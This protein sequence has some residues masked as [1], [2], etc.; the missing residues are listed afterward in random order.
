M[1]PDKAT[2]QYIEVVEDASTKQAPRAEV[3]V[4]GTVKLTEDTIVYIPAPTTDPRDP[5]NMSRWQKIIILIVLSTFSTLGVSMVSGF[6]GLITFYI[7]E[8]AAAGKDYAAISALMTYP[9]LFMGIGNLVGMPLA[10][11]VGRRIVLLVCT[12]ILV[13]GAVLC[14][15]ATSY[16]WHLGARMVIGISAGQSEALV[17]MITQEVFFLHE[18]SKFLM[19]QQTVQVILSTIYCL[20]ASPIAGALTPQGWYGLGAGLAGAQCF[21]AFFFLP[22]TK[23][24]RDL[25]AYQEPTST[26]EDDLEASKSGKARVMICKEKPPLDYL[27]FEKRTWKSDMRLW[28]G[29]PEWYKAVEVLK[30]TCELLF[31][32]NVLWALCLNGL[33]IGTNIAM[34]TT[35][36]TILTAA[37][38]NWPDTSTSYVSCGQIIVAIIALPLL[39]TGSDKLVRMRAE[40]NGGIHEPETRILPLILPIIVGTITA[41]FYGQGAEHPEKY[42]WFV[43]VWS[44]AAYYF[45][46]VGANIVAITYLLDSYPARAGPMLII[47]CAFRGFISFGTSYGTMPFVES[48]GYDGAFG[49][50]GALTAVLGVLGVPIYFWGK[51]IRQFTGRFAKSKSD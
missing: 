2:D 6:G 5:L 38:Y 26:S 7:P 18:R 36:G 43:Y 23:Y 1:D 25:S 29:E 32:P 13:V 19:A 30:Q 12:V 28:I 48:H 40:R 11:A 37:P 41:I 47:I 42:H 16:N 20:F 35:Y 50:F 10:I 17:P 3:E 45:A 14:A 22:E 4:M 34:A 49:T 15:T 21:V 9:T 27:N 8:Y 33:T 51:N 39:G 44:I 24:N 31:F 46:F